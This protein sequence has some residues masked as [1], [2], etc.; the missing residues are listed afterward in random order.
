MGAAVVV[1]SPALVEIF[2]FFGVVGME[3][4]QGTLVFL[5]VFV[6]GVI[7]VFFVRGFDVFV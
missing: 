6:S 4:G 7:E 3:V 1:F 2:L 5:M